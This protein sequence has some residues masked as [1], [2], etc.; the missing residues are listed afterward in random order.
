M[1]QASTASNR[2]AAHTDSPKPPKEL[3]NWPQ[4]P[5]EA[6]ASRASSGLA[7][8]ARESLDQLE[9][10]Q[11]PPRWHK[12]VSPTGRQRNS[13]PLAQRLQIGH[14]K[15]RPSPATCQAVLRSDRSACAVAWAL[16][17]TKQQA[18]TL[19]TRVICKQLSL[20]SPLALLPKA[21][22]GGEA[23]TSR[24]TRQIVQEPSPGIG[25][26]CRQAHPVA[27]RRFRQEE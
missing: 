16:L 15:V 10:W 19:S 22:Q 4:L 20:L 17:L 14:M 25:P 7:A 6:Q 8:Q 1:A 24:L 3:E 23:T 26:A 27:P 2:L 13:C 11:Q 12:S 18:N 5:Q 21:T 9:T